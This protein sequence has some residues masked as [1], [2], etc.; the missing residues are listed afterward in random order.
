[1]LS[2]LIERLGEE[3]AR[4][5]TELKELEEF[6]GFSALTVKEAPWRT[7]SRSEEEVCCGDAHFAG[8]IDW[9]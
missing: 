5:S 3:L 4:L 7:F 1:M 2:Q 9:V 6:V 8:D